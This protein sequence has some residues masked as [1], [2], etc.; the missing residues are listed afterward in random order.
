V[1]AEALPDAPAGATRPG[2]TRLDDFYEPG[3]RPR[4]TGGGPATPGREWVEIKSDRID[5]GPGGDRVDSDAVGASRRYAK[6]A[7]ADW[8]A[9][10]SNE[11]TRTRGDGIVMHWVRKPR[12]QATIDAMQAEL[13]SKDSPIRAVRFGDDPWIERPASNPMPDIH[14]RLREGPIVGVPP[15]KHVYGPEP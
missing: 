12:S 5:Q 4:G 8:D 10:L 9:L 1:P 6:G 7:R 15:K 14:P 3:T 13:F 11:K 2:F